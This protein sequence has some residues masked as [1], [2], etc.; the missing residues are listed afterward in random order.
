RFASA[1]PRT[2][3]SAGAAPPDGGRRWGVCRPRPQLVLVC[4]ALVA[5]TAGVFVLALPHS[6]RPPASGSAKP[7][8]TEQPVAGW[9]WAHET[10]G[11]RLGHDA[12]GRTC[13]GAV[14]DRASVSFRCALD[15]TVAF[16]IA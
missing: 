7:A 15:R 14:L 12:H 4:L 1:F 13:I 16:V 9:T 3:E 6:S 8:H 11:F 10:P 5:A 2:S